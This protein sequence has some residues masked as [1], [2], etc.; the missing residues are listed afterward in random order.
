MARHSQKPDDALFTCKNCKDNNCTE[1]VDVL[2]VVYTDHMICRCSR[3][4]HN[5]EP[6]DSQIADPISGDI[7]GPGLRVTKAGE[8][9]SL[10][11]NPMINPFRGD[12]T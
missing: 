3:A 6:R 8:I 1:C 10:K 4:D 2:R 11:A 12:P 5:G 9:V 7:Y